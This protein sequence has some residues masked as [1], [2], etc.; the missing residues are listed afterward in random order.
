MHFGAVCL[1]GYI[2]VFGGTRPSSLSYAPVD[3]AIV[4]LPRLY[5]LSL[6]DNK[7]RSL[8]PPRDTH[9]QMDEP[10]KMAETDIIRARNRL[11]NERSRGHMLG[12]VHGMTVETAEC[13][14]VLLVCEWRKRMLLIE[15]D[16]L[17]DP[18]LHR[19]GCSLAA[20]GQRAY[21]VGG[22]TAT[23]AADREDVLM[24]DFED[25]L[26]RRRRQETEFHARLERERRSEE[27]QKHCHDLLTKHELEVRARAQVERERKETA[28]M[29]AED[30]R[31]SFPPLLKPA[32]V[33]FVKASR[34]TIWVCWDAMT[35]NTRNAHVHPDSVTYALYKR[36][37]L[38]IIIKGDRVSVEQNPPRRH[39]IDG[40]V[41][42]AGKNGT[43]CVK[44][45]KK[46]GV[47]KNIDRN[48]MKKRFE[49]GEGPETIQH[50]DT[51]LPTVVADPQEWMCIYEGRA[52]S[53]AC[54]NLVPTTVLA[55]M[56]AHT[57]SVT[58]ALQVLGLDFPLYERSLLSDPATF[59]TEVER[60]GV[61]V[62]A[63]GNDT[64]TKRVVTYEV[65]GKVHTMDQRGS[66]HTS[67]GTSVHYI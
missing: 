63:S 52:N 64:V 47:E 19:W 36:I 66:A 42:Y 32:C 56:P 54:T 35:V 9:C 5:A 49:R 45:D 58:F 10:L 34:S 18:P 60:N 41:Q 6:A 51:D 28:T 25:E 61:S 4:S 37:G 65:E 14:A 55:A 21:L 22:W 30:F 67:V 48:R 11:E 43:Y 20:V 31:S 29:S 1:D 57:E 44:Y 39:S 17:R 8:P 38:H 53:Y 16:E 46:M 3:D 23:R 2:V 26:E 27:A 7:W 13:E 40:T 12:A 15:R 50:S 59:K 24:L 62:A 33:R